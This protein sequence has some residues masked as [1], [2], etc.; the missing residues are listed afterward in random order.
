MADH[1]WNELIVSLPQCHFLQTS[2]WAEVKH[3]VGWQSTQMIWRGENDRIIGAANL[4]IRALRPL[5]IGPKMTIGYIPRGPMLDWTNATLRSKALNEIEN[6]ARKEGFIFVKIDPEIIAGKGIPGEPDAE[7]YPESRQISEELISRGWRRSVE[8]IQ[9][10]NTAVLDLTGTDEEWLKRMKQKARYNLRLAQR[11]GVNIRVANDQ[12]LPNLYKMYAQTAA[13]DGFIIREMDY[14]LSVWRRFIQAGMAHPLIAEVEG[15]SVAGLVL[16]HFGKRAWYF[17]GMST[18]LHREKMPNY[19]LQWEAMHI[20]KQCG[21]E[22][23]DLWGAP[24]VFD[25]NDSMYGVFRFKDG[26]GAT[27]IRTE[28]AWDYPIKP[29]LYFVY[30]QVLPRLLMITR[31]LRRGKI[32]QEVS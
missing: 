13:R 9:F 25:Q 10:K 16:F 24:D 32:Q 23:Y 15:Q 6:Y 3:E 18:P 28:G 26:L 29:F 27:V 12:E 31:W 17:Y 8:Q 11:S 19:M 21:C 22:F 4:L 1:V 20:A 14:Y 5:G 7:D 2:E 30:H